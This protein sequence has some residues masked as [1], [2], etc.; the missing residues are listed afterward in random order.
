MPPNINESFEDFAVIVETETK[1]ERI[2]FGLNAIKNVGHTVANEI[3][4]ERKKSGKYSN[5]TDFIERVST[6]DLNKKSIEALAKV[7][8]LD[9]FGE[10]NQ[11]LASVETILNH[12]K[13]FHN[14]KNSNQVSLFGA[15]DIALPEIRLSE[16]HIAT[17]KER[18]SWEKE[19]LG[20]YISDHPVREYAAYFKKIAIPIREITA[21]SVG[22]TIS[23]G[24]VISKVQKV[25][26]KNQKT[27]L[28]VTLEDMLGKME[29]LVFPK[30]LDEM[31]DFW[32]EDK[33]ILASGKISDK[34]GTFKMLCDSAKFITPEEIKQFAR[35]L[36]TQKSNGFHG[37]PEKYSKMTITLPDN[38]SQ[39]ILKKL[40]QFF[41][42]CDR[43][44]VKLYLSI[45]KTRLETPYCIHPEDDLR[46]A[47]AKIIP[48]GKIDLA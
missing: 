28:F 42:R 14:G 40:S 13:K 24:G 18:L 37:P 22:K 47:L 3:V 15:A 27:M 1:I 44:S 26:L 32:T 46:D 35:V 5:L 10:R 31:S 39:D 9:E 11:I 45:N 21:E 7:G 29:I 20:L 12:S 17:Q 23:V 6:K 30:L 43:G 38:S 36:S 4:E 2:R 34:D 48:E 16:A 19:L 41:D 33:V 25:F 8:A